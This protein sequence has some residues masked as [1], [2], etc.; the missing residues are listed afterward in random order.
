MTR[1]RQNY[2]DPGTSKR[3]AEKSTLTSFSRTVQDPYLALLHERRLR[4]R[5]GVVARRRLR[6]VDELRR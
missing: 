4:R 6:G 1:P 3:S 2:H 5:V